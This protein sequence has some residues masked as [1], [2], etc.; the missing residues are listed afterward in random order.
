VSLFC[1]AVKAEDACISSSLDAE[2]LK[3]G[4]IP[5]R[6]KPKPAKKAVSVPEVEKKVVPPGESSAARCRLYVPRKER[7]QEVKE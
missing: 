1:R 2:L 3:R 6:A 4:V 7:Q 5:S